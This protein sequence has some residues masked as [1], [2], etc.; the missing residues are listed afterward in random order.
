MLRLTAGRGPVVL[1]GA[2]GPRRLRDRRAGQCPRGRLPGT[3]ALS[4]TR[5]RPAPGDA[6]APGDRARRPARGRRAGAGSVGSPS[7]PRAAS[8]PQW[9]SFP[10]ALLVMPELILHRVDGRTHLTLLRHDR[11]GERRRRDGGRDSRRDWARSA[12]FRCRYGTRIRPPRRGSPA[13]CPR[14]ASSA[15]S[16]RA[17]TG[18]ALGSSRRWCW[19]G[20]WRS[21]LRAPTIRP[22]VYGALRELF[23]S[24]FCFCCGSPEAAFIGRQPRAAGPSRRRRRDDGGPGRLDQAE[25]RPVGRRPPRASS[26]CARPRTAAST[27]SSSTGSSGRS[28]LIRSGSRLTPEPGLVKVANIQ[29][30]AT[31]IHAQLSDRALG[32]RAGGDAASHPR[33]WRRAS[34]PGTGGDRASSRNST[35]AGTRARSAGWTP[36]RTAS[37][38]SRSAP[39]C[40]GTAP[41]TCSPATGSCADSDP[42]AELAETEV[43]LGALLPVI[44]S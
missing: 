19:P 23:P 6:G 31:P 27:R 12:R 25:R 2:A 43:K 21:R 35:A 9:S 20:R 10:P 7:T 41:P 33:G 40:C 17:W 8:Q 38:A 24:C 44:S 42:E 34:R 5:S 13:P 11:A 4:A 18:S 22:R 30:L 15:P 37:S 26:S 28:A 29:H 39:P 1:L 36:P 14:S 3:G 16:P 32:D